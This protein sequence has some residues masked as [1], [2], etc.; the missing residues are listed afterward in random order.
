MNIFAGEDI[1]WAELGPGQVFVMVNNTFFVSAFWV[2]DLDQRR[3]VLYWEKIQNHKPTHCTTFFKIAL[4]YVYL[5]NSLGLWSAV[6][7]S[8]N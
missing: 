4:Y 5:G 6:D 1:F 8:M 3:E 2:N 7:L